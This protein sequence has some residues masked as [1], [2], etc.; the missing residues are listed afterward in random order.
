MTQGCCETLREM[1]APDLRCFCR[2]DVLDV[3]GSRS[4]PAPAR[5]VPVRPRIRNRRG[6]R[7]PRRRRPS[8]FRSQLR[9]RPRHSRPRRRR[10]ERRSRPRRRGLERRSTP[11]PP[12]P[13]APLAPSPPPP[14]APLARS[15]PSKARRPPRCPRFRC[16]E[17]RPE[18]NEVAVGTV[19]VDHGATAFDPEDGDLTDRIERDASERHQRGVRV[20]Y[21]VHDARRDA[22]DV[23]TR[24]RAR[25]RSS[26]R[27]EPYLRQLCL[28]PSPRWRSRARARTP[29]TTSAR[30]VGVLPS[31]LPGGLRDGRRRVFLR[32][33]PGLG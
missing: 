17:I 4:G 3:V 21:R 20:T 9:S 12:P 16:L 1:N 28:R 8:R 27:F 23:A 11:A 6:R 2:G 15:P 14:G 26:R 10:L 33:P 32:R 13:R 24:G 19:W 18:R 31:V 5:A 25:A 7:V 30:A 22:S 29:A